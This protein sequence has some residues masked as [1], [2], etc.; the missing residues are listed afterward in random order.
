MGRRDECATWLRGDLREW[1]GALLA[2]DRLR[3]EGYFR[4]ETLR[5]MWE[6]NLAGR[7]NWHNHLWPVLMFQAWLERSRGP[8]S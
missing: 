3:R 2:E 8:V 5:A 7:R 4:V 1:A 6:D